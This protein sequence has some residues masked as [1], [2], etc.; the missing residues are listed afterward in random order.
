M[1]ATED[2]LD[3]I[4]VDRTPRLSDY[5]KF[6]EA[7]SWLCRE[8]HEY[9][10]CVLDTADWLEPAIN[11]HVC[12]VH[13]KGGIED[14]G[15]GKGYTFADE[16]WAKVLN[17]FE[18]LRTNKG[19]SI[20]ILAHARVVKFMDPG[21]DGYDRYE[22]DLHKSICSRLQEWCDEVFFATYKVATKKTDEVFGRT[23]TRGIG[24]GDRVLYTSEMPTHLAKRRMSL[25]DMLPLKYEEYAKHLGNGQGNID[26]VVVDGSSKR[27]GNQK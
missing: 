19:M 18:Y 17:G 21:S 26:G 5:G 20:I 7:M 11:A 16:E 27:K 13:G 9:E 15:Y 2:G 10:T 3:D 23:R 12:Q 4:G 22:P 25:P 1:L 24:S 6:Q 8:K 14:F